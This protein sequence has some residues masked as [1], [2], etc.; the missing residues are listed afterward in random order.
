MGSNLLF[1]LDWGKGAGLVTVLTNCLEFY[2]SRKQSKVIV[3]QV[4]GGKCDFSGVNTL[5]KSNHSR[6]VEED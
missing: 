3:C 1:W 2:Y 6:G 4:L 5:L